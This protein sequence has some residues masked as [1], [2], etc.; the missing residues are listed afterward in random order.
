[1]KKKTKK[2]LIEY[3]IIFAIF[4]GLYITGLHTEV[5]GFLQRGVLATGLMDPDLDKNADLAVNDT[6]SKADFSMS[7][8]NSKG[9]NV[10]MEE[11]KGKVI[12]MNLWATWC[13]PCVAEMPGINKLY[14]DIDKDKVAFVMLSID[15]DFQKAIDFNE[16]KGYDFEIYRSNGPIPQMYSSQSI[17][18]TYVID[19]RGNLVLTHMGMGDYDTK[20]FKEFLKKQY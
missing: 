9:E 4:A 20:D 5:L 17:P 7:L 2:N 15:Q 10:A 1:M 8:I 14:K 3:G 16:K 19:A 13:P 18:T 11:L 6:N 12:F